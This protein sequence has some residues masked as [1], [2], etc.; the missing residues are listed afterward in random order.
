MK[1]IIL[2]FCEVLWGRNF[3]DRQE[4]ADDIVL[5][6]DSKGSERAVWFRTRVESKAHDPNLRSQH[7]AEHYLKPQLKNQQLLVLS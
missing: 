5:A 4:A 7:R 2:V 6:E 3:P 1:L